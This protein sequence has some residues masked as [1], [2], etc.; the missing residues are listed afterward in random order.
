MNEKNPLLLNP[1]P[2][3]RMA[4]GTIKQRNPLTGTQV[5]TVTG[6]AK[7][8]HSQRRVLL[9]RPR[10]LLPSEFTN[11]CAFCTNRYFD[12]PPEKSRLVKGLDSKFHQIEGLPA[13]S[14]HDMVAEFRRIPNLFEIV[15]Y[16]YWHENH[17]H[18]PTEAQN[19]RMADYLA[20]AA[21][22]DHVLHV[23]KMRLE[24]SGENHL[25]TIPDDTLLQYA[26][27]L[28]AGGHDVIVARRHYVDGA[29]RTDQNASAGTLSVAEHRAYI[30]YTIAALKDL[31]NLNPAVKYVTAFQNWLKPDGASFDHLHKQLV[32]VDEYGVQIESE[33][34]RVASNPAIYR[35]IL[36]YVGH[37]QMMILGNDYA[38]GFADFGHRYQTIAVW[39]LGPALLPWEYTREQVDGISDVLH[40]LHCAVGPAVPTNEEWYHRPVD[41]DV[42][43]RF[44]I[45]LKQRTSTL[46]GFEG[47]TRIYLNAVDPWTLRDEMVSL[48]EEKRQQGLI[49]STLRLGNEYRLPK[50]PFG[51]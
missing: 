42:P 32:A 46:A 12:T 37:R 25:E 48:L 10:L 2:M 27:G 43:M 14:M 40:A 22:Y 31:Y 39:P 29:T 11:T 41:L 16:D 15:S 51:E 47:S 19:R 36:H 1:D 30:G 38:V 33:A 35:Q 44:R 50:N 13:A 9:D 6:R 7:R 24:A 8:P 17:N 20:S 23:V 45:L 28:F 34:T 49:A 3:D 5:W 21:G 18:Y 26:N 4:D